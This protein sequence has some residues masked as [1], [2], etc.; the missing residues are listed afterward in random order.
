MKIPGWVDKWIVFAV[1]LA[2]G[3]D[4]LVRSTGL[5]L[6]PLECVLIP[7]I[8]AALFLLAFLVWRAVCRLTARLFGRDPSSYRV[9]WVSNA[10]FFTALALMILQPLIFP[11]LINSTVTIDLPNKI[12]IH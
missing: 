8:M 9:R 12:N 7:L 1:V 10:V 3:I 5:P 6:G 4:N 2:L 11:D